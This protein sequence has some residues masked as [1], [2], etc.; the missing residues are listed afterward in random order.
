MHKSSKLTAFLLL[1]CAVS[2]FLSPAVLAQ[3]QGE[4]QEQ[5]MQEEEIQALIQL[6]LP[7]GV[8]LQ[9]ATSEQIRAAVTQIGMAEPQRIAQVVAR[10][11]QL[12]PDQAVNIAAA[13]AQAVP[14]QAAEIGAAVAQA[15]PEQADAVQE[16]LQSAL[17]EAE[18]VA[19]GGPG[20]AAPE[21]PDFAPVDNDP[22]P[23]STE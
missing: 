9:E 14:D 4:Q 5:E 10:M 7:E 17:E 21:V 12:R 19:A 15:V 1:L 6:N 23:G 2:L 3:E 11:A 13:A 22:T 16:T 20:E 8:T 18:E